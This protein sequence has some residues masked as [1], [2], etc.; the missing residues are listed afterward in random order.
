MGCILAAGNCMG[1]TS[2]G[3]IYDDVLASDYPS[4]TP[5]DLPSQ[6]PSD[7]PS[8]MPSD[9]PS[10]LPTCGSKGTTGSSKSK[11][12]ANG[13]EKLTRRLHDSCSENAD[14]TE[15]D[16]NG[17]LQEAQIAEQ[18]AADSVYGGIAGLIVTV[19]LAFI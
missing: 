16:D 4:E 14:S 3:A 17:S 15:D 10:S 19:A 9:T 18:S 8:S 12:K 5:S 6:A 1:A 7:M 11:A 2:K 13:K